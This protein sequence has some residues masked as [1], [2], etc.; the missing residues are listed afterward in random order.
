M[1]P[2]VDAWNWQ[3]AAI[4]HY[5]H[6]GT[7]HADV[8]SRM[9]FPTLFER[10]STRFDNKAPDPT[11]PP[12]RATNYELG[13]SDTLFPGLHVSSAVFY[14]DIEDSIQNAFVAA[15]GMNPPNVAL[16]GISPNGNYY[17]A[18]FSADYDV[19][20]ALRVGGNYTYIDRNL[21]FAE[22][23]VSLA[24]PTT[25]AQRNAVALQQMEGLPKNKAFFY[26]A[27]KATNQLTLTPNL[28]VASNRTALL[29][30]CASTLVQTGGALTPPNANNGNCQRLSRC[31]GAELRQYRQLRTVR[32]SA[33]TTT[34]PRTSRPPWESPTCSTR[35][36]R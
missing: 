1:R 28:E 13:V 21:E 19:S 24:A 8:S 36:S 9:R 11:I 7:V 30:S 3:T 20:R 27:W 32:T 5:S 29:T 15:N 22:E 17:G 23:A 2:E 33:P 34:L 10:Y 4:Y 12:E 16:I 26:L 6:T 18:E 25:P 31:S 35:I 14:S